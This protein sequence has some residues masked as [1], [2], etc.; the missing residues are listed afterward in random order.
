MKSYKL[1]PEETTVRGAIEDG[2]ADLRELG[3]ECRE[4]YDNMT[5]G[6]MSDDHPK[7]QAFSEAAD[8]LEEADEPD[9]DGVPDEVLDQKLTVSNL[10]PKDK[11][12][13]AARWARC[14]NACGKL[15]AAAEALR[16]YEPQTDGEEETVEEDIDKSD[17]LEQACTELAD[18]IE[19]LAD[20]CEGVEFPGLYG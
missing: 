3:E 7:V 11:R 14:S 19:E 17:E 20:N 16:D 2:I 4:A 18:T 9:L 1:V 12:R 8:T 13:S 6:G 5:G 10:T 15:K